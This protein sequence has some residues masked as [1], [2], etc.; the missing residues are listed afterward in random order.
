MHKI[1]SLSSNAMDCVQL[2]PF[3]HDLF[4]AAD[5]AAKKIHICTFFVDKDVMNDVCGKLSH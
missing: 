3:M 2:C 5:S 1:S 4:C